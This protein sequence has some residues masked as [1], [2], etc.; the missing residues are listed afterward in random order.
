VVFRPE[1]QALWEATRLAV[2]ERA[3]V[4]RRTTAA[5]DPHARLAA[6]ESLRQRLLQP[7]RSD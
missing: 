1:V 4:L 2:D 6:F 3:E 5:A 7:G